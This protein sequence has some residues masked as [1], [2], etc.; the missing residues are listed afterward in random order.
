MITKDLHAY[1]VLSL[2]QEKSLHDHG[3][4]QRFQAGSGMALA[5]NG[6][7]AGQLTPA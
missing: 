4:Q 2:H 1:G 3:G 5:R 6:T 7:P